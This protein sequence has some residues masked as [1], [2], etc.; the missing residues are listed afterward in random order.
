M[1][2]LVVGGNSG[3]GL[4]IVREL[5]NRGYEKVYV[6]GKD[7]INTDDLDS[8]SRVHVLERVQSYVTNLEDSDYSVFESI[9]DINALYITVG[10]GRV[11][12][13]ESLIEPEIKNLINVNMESIIQIIRIYYKKI[14]STEDFY[15]SI[16]VS[17]CGRIVS[18]F[19]SVYSATKGGLRFFIESINCELE[20]KGVRNRILEVSP[21]SISGTS[22]GGGKTDL[23]SLVHLANE[24]VD[25]TMHRDRLFI[26]AFE[27]VYKNVVQR[28]NDDPVSFGA[29][30]FNHKFNSGKINNKP[31]VV[32]GYLS[33][34]FDL[35]HIGHLNLL[36]RAK[37]EC[38]YLIVSVHRSGA[39]KGKET[40]IPYEERKAIVQSIK[41]VDIVVE[42]YFEDSDA[43]D[44][45]HYDVLFVGSDY[46]GSERFNRYESLLRGK[47]RIKYFPYTKGTSST[48]LREKIKTVGNTAKYENDS[49]VSKMISD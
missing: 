19:F 16:M 29:E 27:S 12:L 49:V 35:F 30:S 6:V 15:S 1:K 48:Q 21:G 5:I 4:S 39:W 44:T 17:I 36:R 42:D 43:W 10:F 28:Y 32:V 38:D 47:A 8:S 22:F 13:F 34:T 46:K 18:P 7:P 37:E 41:Y 11:A 20:A 33:G 3:I 31:Q 14:S 26:P 9:T 45:F 25:R 40:F 24:I 2:A 23:S